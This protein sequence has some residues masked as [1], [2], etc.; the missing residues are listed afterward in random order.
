MLFP[1]HPR[2]GSQTSQCQCVNKHSPGGCRGEAREEQQQQV[3]RTED[4]GTGS[5][6]CYLGGRGGTMALGW[7]GILFYI[8]NRE[9][10]GCGSP[11]TRKLETTIAGASVIIL[12]IFVLAASMNVWFDILTYQKCCGVWHNK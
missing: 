3:L 1:Q 6:C 8:N 4:C 2:V 9:L 10:A 7:A 11:G 12:T 5:V